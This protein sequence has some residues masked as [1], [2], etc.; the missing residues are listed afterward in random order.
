MN[1]QSID[2]N[3]RKFLRAAGVG[4]ALPLLDRFLPKSAAQE[5]KEAA[6]PQRLVFICTTLGLHAPNFFPEQTG[7]QYS[8]PKYLETLSEFRNDFTIYSGLSHPDQSGND[9][10]SSESTW[11]TS[12]PHPGLAGFRNTISVDQFAAEKLGYVTRFPSLVLGTSSSS[13]SC[14]RSGVSIPAMQHPSKVFVELFLEGSQDEITKQIQNLSEGRSIL[15]TVSAEAKRFAKTSGGADRERLAEYFNSV[16][17]MEKQLAAAESW[18]KKPKPV[19]AVTQP[20]DIANESDLI[21]RAALMFQLIPLALQTDSTRVITV[22]MRGRNDV[23]VVNGV[24]IDHHNLSH[25]GNEENKLAQLELIERAQMKALAGLLRALADKDEAGHRL[26]DRSSILF[27]SN[28]GNANS[29]DARNLPILL[30]GGGHKHGQHLALARGEAKEN[31]PLSNLFVSMLQA[32][33]HEVD[34]FGSSTGT[35]TLS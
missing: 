19:I 30:A 2:K 18:I 23:P 16:R 7:A 32:Q 29:H 13:Q 5:F 22:T 33:G 24:S 11:L 10:H 25:H 28:L 1:S 15:D 12:A 20:R 4:I 6:S 8:P 3:R 26:L 9:G 35:I 34:R 31:T 21:G 14:T 27:G 17:E